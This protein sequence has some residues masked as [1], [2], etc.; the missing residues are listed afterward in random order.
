[1]Y[2]F[3]IVLLPISF[4]PV[5]PHCLQCCDQP[6]HI[7]YNVMTNLVT[8]FTMCGLVKGLVFTLQA[9]CR[10]SKRLVEMQI[11]C[12]A[13]HYTRKRIG[14]VEQVGLCS[15]RSNTCGDC[16]VLMSSEMKAI[17]FRKGNRLKGGQCLD[18]HPVSRLWQYVGQKAVSLIEFGKGSG[19]TCFLAKNQ[20]II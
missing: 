1:M 4:L 2:C 9:M 19:G 15:G 10:S 6:C 7:V 5:L 18:S 16:C 3:Y 13:K 14:L 20:G 17:L 8:L 12:F 11:D